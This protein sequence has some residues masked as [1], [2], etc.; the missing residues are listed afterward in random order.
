MPDT[1]RVAVRRSRVIDAI[2]AACVAVPGIVSLPFSKLGGT[3]SSA[4]TVVAL[5]VAGVSVIARRR[6][7]VVAAAVAAVF[8]VIAVQTGSF[9]PASSSVSGA[10]VTVGVLL[11]TV[12][13]SFALGS[14]RPLLWSGVG[15]ALVIVVTQWNDLNSNF[16]PF[17]TM[18]AIGPWLVG[19]LLRS[20]HDL[21]AALDARG[22]ELASERQRYAAEAVRYERVRIARELHDVVAH[23]MSIVVVQASAGQRLDD[24]DPA[25]TNQLLDDILELARQAESDMAGLTRLLTVD[26][27]RACPLSV[28]A[29][30]Q[31]ADHARAAGTPVE[32]SVT[33]D[34]NTIPSHAAGA[35]SRVL[36]EGLTNAIKHAPGAAVVVSVSV[37]LEN[38]ALEIRNDPAASASTSLHGQGGGHGLRGLAERVT[39]LGGTLHGQARPSG[40]WL[41]S[42][43]IP[44]QPEGLDRPVELEMSL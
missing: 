37:G 11:W 12:V 20:H 31:L 7:P 1:A 43:V 9:D 5:L 18:L 16:N 2:L 34:L 13:L 22:H 30:E 3:S 6:Q 32:L 28:A 15:L 19:W 33:G 36:Q 39:E 25:V 41:L 35:L 8:Y 26:S 17:P 44:T 24:A 4:L 10:L 42:A 23:C 38:T 21:V 40:G 14:W 27:V 29:L